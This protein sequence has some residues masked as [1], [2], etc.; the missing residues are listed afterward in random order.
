MGWVLSFGSRR[1]LTGDLGLCHHKALVDT[2]STQVGES[3]GFNK[4][5]LSVLGHLVTFPADIQAHF[6]LSF[7]G[8]V[9]SQS[10]LGNTDRLPGAV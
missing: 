8:T 1:N 2:A 4:I 3:F 9:D 7:R 6:N 5:W 10:T